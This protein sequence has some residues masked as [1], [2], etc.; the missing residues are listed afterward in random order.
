MFE[1][2]HCI[3]LRTVRYSDTRSI[4]SAWSDERGFV[5]IAM[6]AGKGREAARRRAITMPL[7]PFEGVCDIRPGRDI[8]FMRDMRPSGTGMSVISNPSKLAMGLFMAEVMEKLLRNSQRDEALSRTVFDTVATLEAANA[9]SVAN[10]APWAL[11]RLTVPLG[12]EPDMSGCRSAAFFDIK[13]ARWS[14]SMPV[15]GEAVTGDEA[16]G[17]RL[18]ARLNS[19]NIRRLRLTRETRRRLLDGIIHYYE[20]HYCR[21]SPLHSLEVVRTLF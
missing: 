1:Y 21:L 11:Y 13:A 4:L 5:S 6:P 20:L 7:L 18:I 14:R 9:R 15:G 10:F 17:V 16:D 12:I 2:L 3:A 8:H 19:S